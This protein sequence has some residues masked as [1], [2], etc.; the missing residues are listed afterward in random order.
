MDTSKYISRVEGHALVLGG[1]GEIG[2]EVVRA[3]RANGA[4]AISI[5]YGRNKEA[6]ELLK[7][8]MEENGAV[9]YIGAVDQ[10]D[11]NS[12]T[13]FLEDAVLAVGEE[14][15]VAVNAIGYSPNTPLEEQTL[16]EHR[17]VTDINLHG[18]FF[19]TR[20]IIKRMREHGV[21]G[22]ITIITSTNGINSNSHI[23]SHYDAAKGGLPLHIRN[24]A[25]RY[26]QYGI[27]INGVAP[28]WVATKMNDSLPEDERTKEMARIW[29]GRFATPAEVATFVAFIAGSGS[30][31]ITGQNF[32]IDGGYQ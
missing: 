17:M 30:S 29:M 26:A 19:S 8:E 32:M 24:M 7:T 16:E 11:E 23:S 4:R 20:T 28:G 27:R 10:L 6:A 15:T 13:H 5:G 14:I 12:F 22:T 18:P 25:E 21:T 31:Y 2:A 1:S 9:V 3:L